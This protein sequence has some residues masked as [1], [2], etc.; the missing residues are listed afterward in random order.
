ML[1]SLVEFAALWLY[2][3]R[4]NLQITNENID[5]Q[6]QGAYVKRVAALSPNLMEIPAPAGNT[7]AGMDR[8]D[9]GTAMV[10]L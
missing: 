2:N 10:R 1:F 5:D 6:Q 3:S 7:L 8:S 9:H 4:S